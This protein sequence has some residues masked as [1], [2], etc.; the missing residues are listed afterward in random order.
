MGFFKFK[1]GYDTITDEGLRIL[2]Y[3]KHLWPLSSEGSFAWHTFCDMG[4]GF[5]MAAARYS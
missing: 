3:T 2:T 5:I 4:H 1:N